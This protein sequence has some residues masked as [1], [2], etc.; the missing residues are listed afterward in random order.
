MGLV[1]LLLMFASER[2]DRSSSQEVQMLRDAS[3]GLE[4][5]LASTQSEL[6]K[7]KGDIERCAVCVCVCVCVCAIW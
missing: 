6:L 2:A 1:V 4:R 5:Q 7:A 3:S